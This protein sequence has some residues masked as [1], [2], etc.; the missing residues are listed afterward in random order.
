MGLIGGGAVASIVTIS[1]IV[2]LAAHTDMPGIG[3]GIVATELILY[4]VFTVGVGLLTYFALIDDAYAY[5][6]LS[7]PRAKKGYRGVTGN[8]EGTER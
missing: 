4:L 1:F 6:E 2:A 5:L 7:L 8:P 3:R